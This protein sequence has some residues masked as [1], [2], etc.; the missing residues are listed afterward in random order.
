M[1]RGGSSHCI[2]L[3]CTALQ[4]FPG[5]FSSAD[6]PAVETVDRVAKSADG[7]APGAQLRWPL[8]GARP[9]EGAL[10]GGHAG[11]STSSQLIVKFL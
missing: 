11:A 3:L 8:P 2:A 7:Q 4:W 1:A 9:A 6:G 5:E 10:C